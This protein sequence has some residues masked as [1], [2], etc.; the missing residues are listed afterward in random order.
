MPANVPVTLT[1]RLKLDQD[2]SFFSG[3]FFGKSFEERAEL[4]PD[5]TTL[6]ECLARP[7]LFQQHFL[8]FNPEPHGHKSF[9][10]GLD[11][12]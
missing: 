7:L 5:E 3:S 6:M 2:S 10:D 11:I 12:F 1:G 9:L 4:A 8:Y